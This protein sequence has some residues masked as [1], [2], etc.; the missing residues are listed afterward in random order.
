EIEISIKDAKRIFFLGFGFAEENLEILNLIS[1][2][3]AN[4]KIYGTAKGLTKNEISKIKSY[5]SKT[6][7]ADNPDL[8]IENCDNLTLLRNYL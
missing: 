4:Q 6:H 7:N 5:F 3:N 2:I 1:N 8:I